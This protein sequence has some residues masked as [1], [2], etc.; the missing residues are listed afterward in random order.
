MERG[1]TWQHT[2]LWVERAIKEVKKR[3]AY[4]T[5]AEPEKT[6]VRD[7]RVQSALRLTKARSQQLL[8]SYPEWK[9]SQQQQQQQQVARQRDPLSVDPGEVGSGR[10]LAAGR[11]LRACEWD[12]LKDAVERCLQACLDEEEYG[13]WQQSWEL[14]TAYEHKEALLPG[15]GYSTSAKYGRSRSREGSFVVVQY[16]TGPGDS[17]QPWVAQVQRYLRLVL[18]SAVVLGQD[19]AE[20][21]Q[22]RVAL[23]DFY[24][25]CEPWKD[26]D[27]CDSKVGVLFAEDRGNREASCKD[28]DYPVPLH[29]IEAPL[30][31]S[32]NTGVDGRVGLAAT[33][34]RFKT[35][36]S[37]GRMLR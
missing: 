1:L 2:E 7:A 5:H 12:L 33:P 30:L 29:P 3:T 18:P 17:L 9:E 23:C 19:A 24:K 10:L 34:V 22:M 6:I 8:L 15:G 14:V 35:G 32:R 11:K 26:A 36:G 21:L 37:R 27:V 16:H 28:R 4:R 31:V 13:V 25:Y 20:P